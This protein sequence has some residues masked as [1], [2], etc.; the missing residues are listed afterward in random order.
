MNGELT[1]TTITHW[2]L[3]KRRHLIPKETGTPWTQ[4]ALKAPIGDQAS[5]PRN[6][7]MPLSHWILIIFHRRESERKLNPIKRGDIYRL[8]QS[9]SLRRKG[10]GVY[11]PGFCY[12]Q[13]RFILVGEGGQ[14]RGRGRG[15]DQCMKTVEGG[16]RSF[17]RGI[18][19]R[20]RNLE[21]NENM[22]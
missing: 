13:V 15:H 3:V 22:I 21:E 4:Q 11:F 1:F 19:R 17:E 8:L 18:W 2:S 6:P 20:K 5:S 12:S 10:W 9:E 14:D 16:E 7:Y